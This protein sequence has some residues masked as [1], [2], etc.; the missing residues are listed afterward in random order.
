MSDIILV[1]LMIK[2]GYKRKIIIKTFKMD[3]IFLIIKKMFPLFLILKNGS[4]IS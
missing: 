1:D 2:K 4:S 3:D